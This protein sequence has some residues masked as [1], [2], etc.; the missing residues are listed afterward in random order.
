MNKAIKFL[1]LGL[2]GGAVAIA[3]TGPAAA[4]SEA[5]FYRGKTV[6]IIVGFGPGGGYDRY[7]RLL[8]R[9]YGRHL[10][11]GK[12]KAIVQ[13]MPG[14]SGIKSGNY[15][16]SVAPK[17]GSVIAIFNKSMPTYEILG[18]SA[19]RFKSVDFG[20]IGS[21]ENP[22]STVTV[23][24]SAGI[25]SF[26]DAKKREVLMG[27]ASVSGTQA[28]YP[29]LIN[30]MLGTKF[31]VIAGYRG[32]RGISL[33]MERGEVVGMGLP[34]SSWLSS[35]PD[36]VKQGKLKVLAQLGLEKDPS[37]PGPFLL[38]LVKDDE[39]RAIVRLIS[40][41][42]AIGRTYAA[43]PG[44]TLR[45]LD[46]L[47]RA[48]D[49]AVRDRRLLKDAKKVRVEVRPSTGQKVAQLVSGMFETPKEIIEKTKAAISTKGLIA[50]KCKGSS[51]K[52]RKKRKKKKSKK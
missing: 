9:H 34:W 1:S 3:A 4:Q 2:L 28:M 30:A 50:G 32:S 31:R 49:A 48:F 10:P 35:K 26:E 36:W 12:A 52:C 24:S 13:N 25:G 19:V 18:R 37:I 15:L 42:I 23:L 22:N 27:A 51:K 16:Y 47:R 40:T 45:R 29:A 44:L 5:D 33:A 41:D 7:A 11:G 43:P 21:I 14:A 17:D 38:D 46:S 6:K 8:A 20:W 39:S